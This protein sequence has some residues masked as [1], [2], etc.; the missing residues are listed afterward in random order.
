L[1]ERRADKQA[2]RES[3]FIPSLSDAVKHVLGW[4]RNLN[5]RRVRQPATMRC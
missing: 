5:A 1:R 3:A 2:R 4:G